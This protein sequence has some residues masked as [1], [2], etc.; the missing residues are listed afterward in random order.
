MEEYER[1]NIETYFETFSKSLDTLLSLIS[2]RNF[3]EQQIQTLSRR[4]TR[5]VWT[6][7]QDCLIRPIKRLG[8]TAELEV[9][10][11][12]KQ[13]PEIIKESILHADLIRILQSIQDIFD[14]FKEIPALLDDQEKARAILERH[15]QIV[16][17]I[18][19][20]IAKIEV[21]REARQG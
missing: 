1:Q 16:E 8:D 17:T 19:S 5:E 18:S 15:P 20:L 2:G 11:D 12:I 3:T 10:S 9:E 21:A 13:S 6:Y 14:C 4:L 7:L